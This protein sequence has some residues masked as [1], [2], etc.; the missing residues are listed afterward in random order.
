MQITSIIKKLKELA[1]KSPA[2][3]EDGEGYHRRGI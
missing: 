3:E 1:Q 2:G